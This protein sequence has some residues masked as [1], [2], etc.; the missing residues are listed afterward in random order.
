MTTVHRLSL[1]RL[2]AAS[3]RNDN[4][5]DLNIVFVHGLRGHPK[6]TWTA[7]APAAAAAPAS[8]GSDN[9]TKKPRGL[10]S[11]FKRRT[12]A[13]LSTTVDQVQGPSTCPPSSSPSQATVF[14]PEEYLAADISQACVWTYGYNADIIGGLFQANNKNSISQHGRDLSVRLERE[15]DNEKPIVF[16]VHSL[17]GIILK[18]AIRR[19]EM[20]RNRTKLVIFLGTPHRGST[21]AGWGQIASN[22]A[23][24]ALQDSNKRL[25]ET[26]EVNNEVLDNIHEEFKTIASEGTLKIHTFQ[27]SRGITGMKGLNEKVV[28]DFSSKLDLPRALET[29][30]SID[31]NHMQM[32]RYSSR[33][34][35]GYRAISGVLKA[36][37]RQEL[38]GQ[39]VSPAVVV[40]STED[41]CT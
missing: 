35:E 28:D 2:T 8:N 24:L 30:E 22:L 25:L 17:G 31:A 13:P 10:K 1:T 38:A 15:V 34:D 33:D 16:V 26:L 9:T 6:G 27:E 14:W 20:V 23:R 37:V 36:F 12:A 40:A 4:Q 5:F 18:D 19:S 29:V 32:A 11:L 21:Y 39:Q 41:A 7:A 3:E